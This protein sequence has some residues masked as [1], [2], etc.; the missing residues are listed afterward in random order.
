MHSIQLYDL[1]QC[2]LILPICSGIIYT[3]QAGGTKCAQPSVEGVLLPLEHGSAP[4][5]SLVEALCSLFP[6]GGNGDINS[7]IADRIDSIFKSL[8]SILSIS[9]DRS[10]LHVSMEAWLHV[11]VTCCDNYSG[12][13]KFPTPAILTWPSSD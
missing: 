13:L 2:A 6:E 12:D 9:V 11:I 3:N 7:L 4:S 8:P 1:T 10:Q 5:L